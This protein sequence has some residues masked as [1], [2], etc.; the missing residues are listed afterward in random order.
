ML[1]KHRPVLNARAWKR[2]PAAARPLP[3]LSASKRKDKALI[4]HHSAFFIPQC[5]EEVLLGCRGRPQ[6]LRGF[7]CYRNLSATSSPVKHPFNIPRSSFFT[8]PSPPN[9][10][11]SLT[12][13]KASSGISLQVSGDARFFLH[14]CGYTLTSSFAASF[15]L[16]VRGEWLLYASGELLSLDYIEGVS[17]FEGT[18]SAAGLR[19]QTHTISSTA[20]PELMFHDHL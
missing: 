6:L 7:R 16:A 11:A 20:A 17:L 10:I 5:L 12:S 3:L 19:G 9:S 18:L 2:R 13:T 1:C 4:P 15:N 8:P 14:G